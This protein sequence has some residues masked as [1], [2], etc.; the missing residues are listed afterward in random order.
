MNH[1]NFQRKMRAAP[2]IA[3]VSIVLTTLAVASATRMRQ[4]PA[5][6]GKQ[7]T[8][9]MHVEIDH[10]ADDTVRKIVEVDP[11]KILIAPLSGCLASPKTCEE[12]DADLR[13][14]LQRAAPQMEYISREEALKHLAEYRF[15]QIDAYM[16]ALSVAGAAAGADLV[17]SEDVEWPSRNKC[18]VRATVVDSKR[19]YGTAD[20]ST[21][22]ACSTMIVSE[23]AAT[24]VDP[25]T[26]VSMI[27]T[28]R[29]YG[30]PVHDPG[31]RL[32]TCIHCPNPHYTEYARSR[33]LQGSVKIILTVND[34]G[35][36]QDA[37]VVHAIDESLIRVSMEAIKD[38]VFKPGTDVE[39]KPIACRV[40]VEVT[41]RLLR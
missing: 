41:F 16:G 2:A 33:H 36:P 21:E 32:P 18:V 8:E 26:G 13:A 40:P 23:A 22:I 35:M 4:F 5:Q 20:L 34:R 9:K 38:W 17:V 24:I 39:G 10:L 3:C 15:L 1:S 7:P 11:Q 19:R 27:I 6:D 25:D 29:A 28:G 12:L 14:N 31:P 37:R 30:T